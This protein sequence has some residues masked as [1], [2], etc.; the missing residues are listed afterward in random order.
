MSRMPAPTLWS[1]LFFLMLFILGISSQFGLAEVMCTALYDQ[2]PSIRHHKGYLAV[3]VCTVLFLCGL[4]MTTRVSLS[5]AY[6]NH[7][8]DQAGIYY[9]N[10]FN[11]YSASF[12]LMLLIILELLL[13]IYIYGL[14]ACL[15]QE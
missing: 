9:F 4:V 8:C 1:L 5:Y 10:I 12:S 6:T 15:I 7:E 13:V 14:C 2:F 3:G 11:D